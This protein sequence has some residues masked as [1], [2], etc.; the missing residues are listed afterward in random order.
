MCI[1]TDS[2]PIKVTGTAGRCSAIDDGRRVINKVPRSDRDVKSPFPFP[3]RMNY[4]GIIPITVTHAHQLE[5]LSGC[6]DKW[7]FLSFF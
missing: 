2:H 3:E 5:L 4:F 6:L 1:S 7:S